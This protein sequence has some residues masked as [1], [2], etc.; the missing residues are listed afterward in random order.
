MSASRIRFKSTVG[1]GRRAR[2]D[3]GNSH[4]LRARRNPTFAADVGLRC[5]NPTYLLMLAVLLAGDLLGLAP[6][7]GSVELDYAY[8][9]NGNLIQ[10]DGKHYEYNDANR[11]VR[12][13]HRDV[14]GPVIA[15]Y[16]YDAN[17]Q[18]VKK[19]ENGVTTYYIGKHTEHESDA[20]AGMTTIYHFF[21][22]QRVA[23]EN[24]HSG[25]SFLHAD[26]L[27]SVRGIS[28]S[29]GAVVQARQYFPFGRSRLATSTKFGFTGKEQDEASNQ[30]YFE[31][32]YYDSE[33]R[34]FT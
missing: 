6:A 22:N 2:D 30:Y 13:R 16:V 25:L 15:E 4:I 32:R 29:F 18:R 23:S 8:D 31:S 19:V 12:V 34:Y 21:G 11:L 1:R 5:A 14:S 27:Q 28:D 10:G 9:A 26:H 3:L 24:E 17:G 33:T 7:M 20:Y